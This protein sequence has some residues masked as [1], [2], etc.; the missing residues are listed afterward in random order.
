VPD[1]GHAA[2]VRSAKANDAIHDVLM[3][4]EAE[5][6][7]AT[8]TFH[9]TGAIKFMQVKVSPEMLPRV[10]PTRDAVE[11][12]ITFAQALGSD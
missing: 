10:M 1:A 8:N 5:L 9:D 12:K 6:Q 3:T 4:T 7:T 11:N 2:L